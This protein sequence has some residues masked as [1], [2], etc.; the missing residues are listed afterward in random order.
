MPTSKFEFYLKLEKK[1][2]ARGGE[3]ILAYPLLLVREKSGYPSLAVT[4]RMPGA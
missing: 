4:I 3:A 1:K 2:A